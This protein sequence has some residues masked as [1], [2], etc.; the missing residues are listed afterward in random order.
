[1]L[2]T[3]NNLVTWNNN[4]GALNGPS[5]SIPWTAGSGNKYADSYIATCDAAGT[6]LTVTWPFSG[7][8]GF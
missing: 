8:Y 7:T 3:G 4:G 6:P 5:N 2:A 1:V